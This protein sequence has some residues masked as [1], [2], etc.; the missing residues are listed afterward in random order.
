[1][2]PQSPMAGARLRIP[3][4][5]LAALL[6]GG[7]M[8]QDPL[9]PAADI[10]PP[11]MFHTYAGGLASNAFANAVNAAQAAFTPPVLVSFT[12]EVV[13]VGR[14]CTADGVAVLVDDPY[15]ASPAGRIALIDR[16]A[17]LF[18]NKVARAQLA[19]A[20]GVIVFNTETGG[21][22]VISMGGNSPVTGGAPSLIGTVITIPALFIGHADGVL[23]RDHSGTVTV[24]YTPNPGACPIGPIAGI[25]LG[26]LTSNLF[27]FTDGSKDA[28]WQSS[29]KGYFGDVIVDG[30]QANERTSGT[31]AYA[32]AINTSAAGLGG[33]QKI[34]DNNLGQAGWR[35]NVGQNVA[36]AEAALAKAFTQINALSVTPGY[37]NRSAVSLNGINT[38]NG[39]AE[40]IVVN[41]TTGFGVSSK[42]N[43]TGDA[44]D[45]FILRWDTDRNSANGY[46]G[47]VKFQ[48]G[49]AIV[50]LGGLRPS[51]FIHVA[52]NLNA[53]GGG[54]NPA[55]PYPQGPRRN[56]GAGPLIDGASDF[57]GGGFF[58]GYWL[59]TGNPAKNFET[60]P[61]SN[62]IFVG[63]WY[64]TTT[65]FSMTG[66]T[67]GVRICPNP[68][69]FR[70][71]SV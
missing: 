39:I 13:H 12:G 15:L 30:V 68:Q 29:S 18:D 42:I 27:V 4:I 41:V 25:D 23:L 38:Q 54:T 10:P 59:T 37:D 1:M 36:A 71:G 6:A 49:G 26:H 62:A 57:D 61:F 50:P 44:S 40:T 2:S 7:C 64:S 47:E 48:S 19:G 70:S 11:Q 34:A 65:K 52:G 35:T 66:G 20:I 46:Q 33:W 69:T 24:T 28:N 56:N 22:Q 3:A 14:G 17:C 45:V 31:F 63:G 43:V 60:S 53:S 55:L 16:G 58:T 51:N 67:S 9:A 8:E 32:G 21:A 5:A